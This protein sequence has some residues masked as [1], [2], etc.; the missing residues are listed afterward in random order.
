[1]SSLILLYKNLTEK[2]RVF[3]G[4]AVKLGFDL[5]LDINLERIN[6]DLPLVGTLDIFYIVSLFS[7]QF[8]ASVNKDATSS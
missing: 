2:H 8:K 3:F 6:T 7:K 1:M 4:K 5:F